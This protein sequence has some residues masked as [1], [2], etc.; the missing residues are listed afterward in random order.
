MTAPSTALELREILEIL[1]H[2]PPMLMVDRVLEMVP[3]DQIRAIKNVSGNE[4]ALSG[5]FP[6]RPVMPGV[7]LIEAMAQA[8]ALLVNATEPFDAQRQSISLLGVDRA[9]F[10]RYVVAGDQLELRGKISSHRSGTWRLKCQALVNDELVAEAVL[11]AAVGA[12]EP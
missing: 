11:L 6:D 9:R 5:H 8:S 7:L 10:R 2:R 1:P 3:G 4:P 12:P